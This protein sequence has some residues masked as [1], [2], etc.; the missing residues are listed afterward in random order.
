MLAGVPP[1]S[2]LPQDMISLQDQYAS[3]HKQHTELQQRHA[4]YHTAQE[5]KCCELLRQR[6]NV[7]Q[8]S[9]SL[10][11]ELTAVKL[12]NTQ[13][14]L[15]H[16]KLQHNAN[17][18]Q[19]EHACLRAANARLQTECM[20]LRQRLASS[21]DNLARLTGVMEAI[22]RE[23]HTMAGGVGGDCIDGAH[24]HTASPEHAPADVPG[25]EECHPVG[26]PPVQHDEPP[27][28]MDMDDRHRGPVHLDPTACKD[29]A[30]ASHVTVLVP[31]AAVG[32][33]PP[34]PITHSHGS[35]PSAPSPPANSGLLSHTDMPPPAGVCTL[36]AQRVACPCAVHL[37]QLKQEVDAIASVVSQV[38]GAAS[39]SDPADAFVA[40]LQVSLGLA[41]LLASMPACQ[42]C[43]SCKI[44]NPAVCTNTFSQY[45][46]R[47]A[48]ALA[49][50]GT[51]KTT[52]WQ[53]CRQ[54]LQTHAQ[55][56]P[57]MQRKLSCA[58]RGRR[59]MP[60]LPFPLILLHPH[61]TPSQ[62]LLL[63]SLSRRLAQQAMSHYQQSG[64]QR[65]S[66]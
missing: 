13:L 43:C 29:S 53:M 36:L 64:C 61:Q 50:C 11:R 34:C 24:I 66:P 1:G 46:A 19:Q 18:L 45:D 39:S 47:Q 27:M 62:L 59:P 22:L 9:A 38:H 17:K 25:D 4:A 33:S 42:I 63:P 28:A 58:F 35:M 14:Q 52:D 2:V 7:K 10:Q 55:G 31:S 23:A 16:A 21:E 30:E 40:Q 32:D 41:K 56:V 8:G 54:R 48:L 44:Y 5:D 15:E 26:S 37:L 20:E 3:L 57:C 60:M 65:P 12:A 51:C 6:T 49:C